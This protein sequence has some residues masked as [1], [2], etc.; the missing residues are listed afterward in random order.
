LIHTEKNPRGRTVLHGKV[1]RPVLVAVSYVAVMMAL[2]LLLVHAARAQTFTSLYTFG[3]E[4][5]FGTPPGTGPQSPLILGSDGNFY[6]TTTQGGASTFGLAC[7]RGCGTVYKITPAGVPTILYTFSVLSNPGPLVQGGDGNFYGVTQ[8]G[9]SSSGQS[10]YGEQGGCG[11]IFKITPAGTLTTI[12]NFSGPDGAF[13]QSPLVQGNDGNFYGTTPVGGSGSNAP[14]CQGCGTVFKITPAGVLT[15]LYE[16]QGLADGYSPGAGLTLGSDGNIYGSTTEG[17]LFPSACIFQASQPSSGCGTLF[18]INPAGGFA[19]VYQFSG[20]D[21]IEPQAALTVGSDGNLYG[22]TRQGGACT[23]SEFGCGT[24]FKFVSLSGTL[25]TLE[26]F[27]SE[28]VPSSLALGAD[29]NFY[30][31]ATGAGTATEYCGVP[32]GTLFNL[33][34][35]GAMTTLYSFSGPDGFGPGAP[36]FGTDGNLY[37]TT[38]SGGTVPTGTVGGTVFRLGLC[39]P[40]LQRCASVA[41]ESNPPILFYSQPVTFTANVSAVYGF[42]TPTGSVSFIDGNSGTVL[43]SAGL[44][45]G[46][47]TLTTSALSGGAHSVTAAYGGDANFLPI[48][49]SILQIVSLEPTTGL[50]AVS[51]NPA[52]TNQQVTL[53]ASVSPPSG[54]QGTQPTGTVTFYI[55]G[56]AIGAPVQLTAGQAVTTTSFSAAGTYPVYATYSGDT[57]FQGITTSTIEEQVTVATTTSLT[58][59][60]SPSVVGQTVTFT[61]AINP[62]NIP[63]GDTVTFYDSGT[64]IGSAT[65][66]SG[67]AALS[68]SSLSVGT[69]SVTSTF[70][71]DATYHA[72]TSTAVTQ[73]V[74]A[75]STTTTLTSGL[76]PSTYSQ[77]VTLTATVTS[78]GPSPTGVVTFYNGASSLG[79]VTLSGGAATLPSSTLPAGTDSITAAYSGN[80][81]SANSTSTVLSQVVAQAPTTTTLTASTNPV[82][83]NQQVTFTATVQGQYGG[84]PIGTVAF[85]SNGTQIGAAI[86]ISAGQAST[87]TSFASAGAY[88][89]TAVYSG[90]SNFTGSS[91][92]ALSETVNLTSTTT[93][94]RSSDSPSTV[95]VAVTFTATVKSSKGSIPNGDTVTFYDGAAAIGN[96]T[97][98]SGVASFGTSSLAAGTHSITATYAGDAIYRS[99]TSAAVTQRVIKNATATALKSDTN[100]STYGQAVTFTATVSSSG[101]TPT[102][103]VTFRNGSAALGT[104]TLAGGVAT[105][106][107]ARLAAG[108]SSITAVYGGDAASSGSTSSTLDQSV[109]QAATTTTVT[110]SKNPSTAGRSVT[111]TATVT[112]AYVTPSGTVTFTMGSTT[113]GTASLAGG[114]GRLAITT[115]PVGADTVTAAYVPGTPADFGGSSGSIIQTVN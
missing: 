42:G 18:S 91:A 83:T 62:A 102:G 95:G 80:A 44:A 34:P 15:T 72:S 53:T 76:N 61:A 71:G 82:S 51:P 75:Y 45:N 56:Q 63:N 107:D 78:A 47:A 100:P 43:G 93:S 112:S 85:Y 57:N 20:P 92:P 27:S 38:A 114:M 10:C 97:T 9:G 87:T 81:S 48:A 32:C 66:T 29:G 31:S 2:P 21:G 17:G 109:A 4:G 50:L 35:A 12:Y 86:A 36:T 24:F 7:Q 89:I 3:Y 99:S 106:T 58:T 96:A 5:N 64:S 22:S 52:A 84:A 111:F 23:A 13:P 16:F 8:Y 26:A 110:S 105:F 1:L 19:T 54:Y 77:S 60:G 115:L 103:T 101:P 40:T 90:S 69:H 98:S 41:E 79:I 113:L 33:T 37:G 65:T 11:T 68:T 108:T 73:V 88:S 28:I 67:S 59:S 49:A 14:L 94:L 25:T 74:N 46:T 55:S 6:G 30:G 104:G 70:A 39:L